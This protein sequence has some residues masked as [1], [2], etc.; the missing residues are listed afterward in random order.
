MTNMVDLR[1]LLSRAGQ[2]T[3]RALYLDAW[4]WAVTGLGFLLCAL[5]SAVTR[6]CL[7]PLACVY[8]PWDGVSVLSSCP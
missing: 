7:R 8:P 2:L 1:D 5:D 3:L 4:F 6:A